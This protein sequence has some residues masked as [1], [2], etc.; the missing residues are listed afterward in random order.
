LDSGASLHFC[1]DLND[2]IEYQKYKP[3]ERTL[4]TTATYTIYVEGEGTVLL[5]HKVDGKTI[6]MHLEH[7]L[8]MPQ[9]TTRLL[10]MANFC[11]K[12]CASQGTL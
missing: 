6:K 3:H 4:V 11:Y 12:E 8:H 5:K 2:F 9:I 1:F 10:S 7:V